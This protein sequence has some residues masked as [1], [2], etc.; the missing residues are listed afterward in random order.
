MADSIGDQI[1]YLDAV[2]E[3][4]DFYFWF[5]FEGLVIH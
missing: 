4:K 1:F 2:I 3:L 5:A